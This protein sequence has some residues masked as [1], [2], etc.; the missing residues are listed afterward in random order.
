MHHRRA[1]GTQFFLD[2]ELGQPG[3][4]RQVRGRR[5][6]RHHLGATVRDKAMSTIAPPDIHSIP[7]RT[8]MAARE[9]SVSAWLAAEARRFRYAGSRASRLRGYSRYL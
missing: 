6:I 1:A 2:L 8:A 5:R 7:H 4:G 3:G 9:N